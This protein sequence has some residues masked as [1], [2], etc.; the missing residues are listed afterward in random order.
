MKGK[1][2]YYKSHIGEIL[3][4]IEN[5]YL[6]G[7]YFVGQK[8]FVEIN[9][10]DYVVDDNNELIKRTKEFLDAYFSGLNPKKRKYP[11]IFKRNEFSK[12]CLGWTFK[13]SLWRN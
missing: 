11:F 12:A 8:H 10:N 13:Y 2:S 5:G 9:R 3:I 1:I 6:V 7:L 4:I